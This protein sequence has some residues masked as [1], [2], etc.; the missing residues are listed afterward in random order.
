MISRITFI[1]AFC[2]SFINVYGQD[3]YHIGTT[4]YYHNQAYS[5]TGYPMVKRSES[6]K[7]AFLSA[8][9]L[10][11]TP[12]GYEID[13]IRPLSQ[14]GTDDPSNMQLLTI[15]QHRAK[16]ASERATQTSTAIKRV[17][18]RTTS[19][20]MPRYNS[21]PTYTSPK[22]VYTPTSATAP[23]RVVQTGP[24][25]GTYYINSNGNKTYVKQ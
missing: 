11:S 10:S 1:V 3:T 25:G 13:H 19:T 17:P 7:T 16:T 5:T 20:A 23:S 21:T 8:R 9:G 2:I 4:E 12:P 24:R 14:G 22:P 18:L 15:E 6:N